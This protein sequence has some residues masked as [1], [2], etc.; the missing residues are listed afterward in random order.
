[1]TCDINTS[2]QSE[3]PHSNHPMQLHPTP[4]ILILSEDSD[5][6]YV[7]DEVK[8]LTPPVH[9]LD[10]EAVSLSPLPPP[11]PDT[12]ILVDPDPIAHS[13]TSNKNQVSP[14]KQIHN[15]GDGKDT[16][17][18]GAGSNRV[19]LLPTGGN[20][21][22]LA[23]STIDRN[24][25]PQSDSNQFENTQNGCTPFRIPSLKEIPPDCPPQKGRNPDK[26]TLS[27]ATYNIEGLKSNTVYLQSLQHEN[28]VI[29]IQEHFLWDFKKNFIQSIMP[30][31]SYHIRCHDH[32]E[33]L[34]GFKLPRG[35]G[36]CH[37][38]AQGLVK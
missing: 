25:A 38:M 10:R 5:E 3:A 36:G 16:D 33:P 17:S 29:C 24:T 15:V 28:T 34:S 8:Q 35:R 2:L 6:S 4:T 20:K 23:S 12:C 9:G 32:L 13:V 11:V 27:V 22:Q 26:E 37:F 1:M 7:N 30:T 14:Q 19:N 31:L 18:L 21:D